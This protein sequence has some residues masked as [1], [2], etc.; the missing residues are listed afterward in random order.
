[1]LNEEKSSRREKIPLA[2]DV[3]LVEEKRKEMEVR[4]VVDL[5]DHDRSLDGIDYSSA[6]GTISTWA[7]KVFVLVGRFVE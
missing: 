2:P 7:G 3:A 5:C 6:S 1:M 4:F